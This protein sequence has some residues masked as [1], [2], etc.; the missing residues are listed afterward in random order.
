M[1]CLRPEHHK[2]EWFVCE[3]HVLLIQGLVCGYLNLKSCLN[4]VS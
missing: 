2:I 4:P 1:F 3:E